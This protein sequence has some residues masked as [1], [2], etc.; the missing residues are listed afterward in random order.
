[1]KIKWAAERFERKLRAFWWWRG[2][3][4]ARVSLVRPAPV[5][6]DAVLPGFC[7]CAVAAGVVGVGEAR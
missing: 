2:V 1:M 6:I 4:S 3:G 5:L 7:A